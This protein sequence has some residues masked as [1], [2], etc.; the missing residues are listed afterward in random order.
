MTY[1]YEPSPITGSKSEYEDV[2]TI[3]RIGSAEMS[4]IGKFEVFQQEVLQ[5]FYRLA[6]HIYSA[7]DLRKLNLEKRPN[8]EWNLFLPI[9]LSIVGNFKGQVPG[10]EFT[11]ISPQDQ[12]GADLHQTLS[13]YFLTQA[14]DIEYEISK[15]FLWAVVGRIG[16]LKTSWSYL[17]D[18]DGMIL[19]E[20]Y[21]SLRIKFD[22]N[23]RKRDTSD[24][25]YM[26]D[27]G[28][29][30]ASEIIDIYAKNNHSLRDEI[31]EKARMIVGDSAL[32]KGKMKK[33]LLTWAER[34]L[35][36]SLDY[37]GQKHGFDSFSDADVAYNYGATWYNGDGRF[38]V[39]DWYEKRQQPIMT[40]T[41]LK[42]GLSQDI[43]DLVKDKKRDS[44]SEKNWYDSQKLQQILQQY[45][46]PKIREEWR[47]VIWQTSVVPALNLKLYDD[48]QKY[49]NGNFKFVP[50]LAHDFHPDILETKSVLDNIIDPVS[51]YNL[52]RN[53]MLTYVMKVTQ[54]GWIAEQGAV[55]GFEDELMSNELVG[56]KKVADGAISNKRMIKLEPPVMP[57]G[58]LEE[59]MLEKEDTNT[60]SGQGPNMQGRKESA[61]ETGKLYEQR[62]AQ[63]SLLQDWLNDNAQYALVMVAQN[64]L[65][66]AQKYLILPRV[67]PLLGD[68]SDPQWLQLNASIMGK[69]L[70]DVSFG[71]YRIKISKNPLG[72]KALEL[73]FQKI[74]SM[75][76]WLQQLDP[77]YV[78][79]ITTLEH[80]GINARFKMIAHIKNAQQQIQQQVQQK[81]QQDQAQQQQQQVQQQQD[82]KDNEDAKRMMMNNQ[83][84]DLLKKMNE[85]H[86]STMDNR[87]VADTAV[88]DHIMSQLS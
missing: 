80:S 53:T 52:R 83:K 43:T 84:V 72:K 33:M 29:Y 10:L 82:S 67:I 16:W 62:V 7:Q 87:Q 26:S 28:F 8:F 61:K 21:D 32:K 79:P 46:E 65:A 37:Q 60:I 76:Q 44:L 5:N 81:Q 9:I 64:N 73:E 35:N 66:L 15:A 25:R 17:K 77:S 48:M 59:S 47:D 4:L 56:L 88:A 30:E 54:G 71:R 45:N 68:D 13:N 55:K 51:S 12:Q 24:M 39:I 50:V 74:M 34:F 42:T 75:N 23:W 11:G 27:S 2:E 57:Q 85:L 86:K 49:Q 69:L 14:N 1:G 31:Y 63:A 6:G 41:D 22:T 78:D 19:I 38:K 70:N 20:W 36:A 18:P 58:L 3:A 40:V